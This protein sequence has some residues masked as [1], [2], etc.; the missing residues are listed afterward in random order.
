MELQILRHGKAQDHGH[1]GGDGG[2]A[3]VERGREQAR[4]AAE[5]VQRSGRVPE[6]VLTSPVLRSRQTAEVFCKAAEIDKPIEQ[7]WL[8]CGMSPETA[9]KELRGFSEFKRVMLV[10]HEP[11]LSSLV[12]HLLGCATSG[13]EVK[14]GALVGLTLMPSIRHATLRYLVPPRMG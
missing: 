11:D 14:K 6:V 12:E 5:V 2:R 3:L 10:G 9:V 8:A 7:P 1:P 13:I 4:W